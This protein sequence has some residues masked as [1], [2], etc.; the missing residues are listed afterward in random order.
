LGRLV[1][2]EEKVGEINNMYIDPKYRGNGY[3]HLILEQLQSRARDFGFNVLRLDAAG[4]NVVAQNLYRKAG[5]Y[6]IERYYE[7]DFHGNEDRRLMYDEVVYM[8]KK[9]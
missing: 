4:F 2:L 7:V 9:L 5:F 1:R 6:E 3:G 8:E